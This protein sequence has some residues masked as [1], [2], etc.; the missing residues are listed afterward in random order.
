MTDLNS[1]INE[2]EISNHKKIS[3][4]A[5]LLKTLEIVELGNYDIFEMLQ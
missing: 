4:T 2:L 5:E 1:K 3:S